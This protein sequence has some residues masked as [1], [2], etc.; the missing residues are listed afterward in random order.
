MTALL[1][2]IA[3]GLTLA[4]VL[5]LARM[6]AQRPDGGQRW[7]RPVSREELGPVRKR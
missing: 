2:L 7:Q 4:A 3:I 6:R 1:I 5:Y